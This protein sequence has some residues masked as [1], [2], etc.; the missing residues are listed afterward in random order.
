MFIYFLVKVETHARMSTRYLQLICQRKMY[1]S[2]RYIGKKLC[3]FTEPFYVILSHSLFLSQGPCKPFFQVQVQPYFTCLYLPWSRVLR[4]IC[5]LRSFLYRYF[6]AKW[7]CNLKKEKKILSNRG[8]EPV[9]FAL[10]ARRS[11][12]LS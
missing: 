2:T 8:I 3:L 4:W 5:K 9:T 7:I 12:Q 11:N 1:T 6:Y 10:L